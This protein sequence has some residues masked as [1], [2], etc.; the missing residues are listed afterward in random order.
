MLL[1]ILHRNSILCVRR[2]VCP[3]YLSYSSLLWLLM[4]LLH[5]A[6]TES[7]HVRD[8][9][10]TESYLRHESVQLVRGRHLFCAAVKTSSNLSCMK[11]RLTLNW[12]MFH[13]YSF[14]FCW[15]FRKQCSVKTHNRGEK[16]VSVCIRPVFLSSS[17]HWQQCDHISVTL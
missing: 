15:C 3:E 13:I 16:N 2:T 4:L 6:P 1:Q 7:N 9:I 11:Y 10:Q 5:Q 14:A 17:R 12:I 8:V